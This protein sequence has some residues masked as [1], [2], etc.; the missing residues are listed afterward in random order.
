MR[1]FG[2]S[3]P[4]HSCAYVPSF[5]ETFTHD[6]KQA[7]TIL[8][9]FHLD[10]LIQHINV[11]LLFWLGDMLHSNKDLVC[12]SRIWQFLI[13]NLKIQHKVPIFWL[14][15]TAIWQ[16]DEYFYKES[17]GNHFGLCEVRACLKFMMVNA[18]GQGQMLIVT[19]L[20]CVCVGGC[21]YSGIGRKF[22][23]QPLLYLSI[24]EK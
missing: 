6:Y 9:S 19:V 2:T 7:N 23:L 10:L 11:T 13:N 22:H 20:S 3:T 21:A 8:L 18:L 17:E 24:A 12:C 15:A 16:Y 4:V 5:I 1:Q 14:E